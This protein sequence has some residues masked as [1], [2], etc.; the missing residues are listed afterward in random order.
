M[1]SKEIHYA[2][3]L[4]LVD[5]Y[6]VIVVTVG[7]KDRCFPVGPNGHPLARTG[8]ASIDEAKARIAEFRSA[9]RSPDVDRL[10]PTALPPERRLPFEPLMDTVMRVEIRGI[11][12]AL[13]GL[14]LGG[15]GVLWIL[16][17]PARHG[18]R[19][20]KVFFDE[21]EAIEAYESLC[22]ELSTKYISTQL[23]DSSGDD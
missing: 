8:Y 1:K 3:T 18:M 10:P 22:V 14:L 23:D 9:G 21:T 11:Y 2:G 7:R 17:L 20:S 15:E 16:E 13:L 5:G 19:T 12:V 4:S 6:R